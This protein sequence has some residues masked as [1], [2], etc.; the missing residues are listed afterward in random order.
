[1]VDLSDAVATK[2][3][4]FGDSTHNDSSNTL[5]LDSAVDYVIATK[6]FNDSILNHGI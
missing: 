1:M 2:I 3:L 4:P 5:I 6:R